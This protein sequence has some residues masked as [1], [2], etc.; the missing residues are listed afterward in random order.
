MGSVPEFRYVLPKTK[1]WACHPA[2]HFFV[3]DM[4]ESIPPVLQSRAKS[5]YNYLA[6]KKS[7]ELANSD[8]RA[9]NSLCQSSYLPLTNSDG[10]TRT[11]AAGCS[12]ACVLYRLNTINK[13]KGV[14]KIRK[15]IEKYS[16]ATDTFTDSQIVARAQSET[17]WY[18]RLKRIHARKMEA[19]SIHMNSV[20][21]NVGPYATSIAVNRIRRQRERSQEI[22][23]ELVA[24]S[25]QGD[26]LS[27]L[28]LQKHSLANPHNRR[29]ELMVR[30]AGFESV[31]NNRGDVGI[32]YTITCP[33][34]MHA[35]HAKSGCKNDKY[36]GTDPKKAQKYLCKVWARIRACLHRQG[37]RVYGLRVAEPQ[38]DGTPHWHILL[39][40]DRQHCS[41]VTSAIRKY[42]LEDSGSERGAAKHRVTTVEVDSAKGSAVGYIAKYISKNIDGYNLDGDSS[43]IPSD[44]AAERVLAW[45]S[46]WG[47]RQFQQVG[48]PP[49]GVWRELRRMQSTTDNETVNNLI[50]AADAADWAEFV[51]GMGGPLRPRNQPVLCV[52]RIWSDEEGAYGDPKGYRVLGLEHGDHQFITREKVW[53]VATKL[54]AENF[55]SWAAGPLEF[56]Q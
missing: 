47:I 26:I 43:G 35:S 38:H 52:F 33:S 48:G 16:I 55:C 36:D 28:E 9:L 12:R 31:A 44:Q 54:E 2:D 4:Q 22:L 11:Q 14:I 15:Y 40:M 10:D 51:S 41:D 19:A 50:E 30:V 56:C 46:T 5:H 1:G 6:R 20:N 49:V 39:F 34:R 29:A 27:L 17:W 24:V 18:R 23:S 53:T 21:K 13:R 25:D 45:A 8:L 42:S 3:A 7:R 32:F 37:I